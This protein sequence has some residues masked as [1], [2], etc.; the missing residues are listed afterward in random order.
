MNQ[1][2][3]EAGLTLLRERQAENEYFGRMWVPQI[4]ER[5]E[6]G[7]ELLDLIEICLD[8][9]ARWL[10]QAAGSNYP[11]SPQAKTVRM[12]FGATEQDLADYGYKMDMEEVK[13]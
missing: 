6:G 9:A 10:A 8:I 5:I 2:Q 1:E 11:T 7:E 3:A 12:F 4:E 13:A